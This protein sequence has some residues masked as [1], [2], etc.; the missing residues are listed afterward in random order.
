MVKKRLI[1][2]NIIRGGA[3]I[4]LGDNIYLLK[5]KK[6]SQGGIDIGKD[7][8][9]EGDEVVKMNPK[10]IKVVT[11]QKI[12]G[13]KSPAELVV[14]ASSTGEQE[15]VFNNV[16]RYQEKFKDRNNLNDDGTK[17]AKFG[18]KK[19]LTGTEENNIND[20]YSKHFLFKKDDVSEKIQPKVPLEALGFESMIGLGHIQYDNSYFEDITERIKDGDLGLYPSKYQNLVSSSPTF[21]FIP[22]SIGYYDTPNYKFFK[23]KNNNKYYALDAFYNTTGNINENFEELS[24]D[25]IRKLLPKRDYIGGGELETALKAIEKL[26]GIKDYI[27]TKSE[28]YGVNPNNVLHRILQEGFASKLAGQYNKSSV[29]DQLNFPWQ[30]YIDNEVSGYFDIGLDTYMD[31]VKKGNVKPRRELKFVETY[32]PNEDGRSVKYN[33][34]DFINLYDAIE[35]KIAFM[36][37]LTKLGKERG[38]EG[39]DLKKF[40][41]GAYNMG[42]FRNQKLNDPEYMKKYDFKDYYKLGGMKQ[43]KDRKKA[44]VGG[45][46]ASLIGEYGMPVAAG[47]TQGVNAGLMLPINLGSVI[48]ANIYN[49]KYLDKTKKAT[50]DYNQDIYDTSIQYNVDKHNKLTELLDK[51]HTEDLADLEKHKITRKDAIYNPVKLNTKVNI[52]PRLQ[53]V[54]RDKNKNIE[55]IIK[56]T[57][58]SKDMLNRVRQEVLRAGD[59]AIELEGIK[60][61]AEKQLQNQDILQRQKTY[62]KQIDANLRLDELRAKDLQT[63]YNNLAALKRGYNQNKLSTELD[64]LKDTYNTESLKRTSDYNAENEYREGRR[65]NRMNLIQG[66]SDSMGQFFNE[67]NNSAMTMAKLQAM[68]SAYG[69]NKINTTSEFKPVGLPNPT[70]QY[71]GNSAYN[72][73]NNFAET[74]AGQKLIQQILANGYNFKLGGKT[75]IKRRNK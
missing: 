25:N 28:E 62:E 2:P 60:E 24:Y 47:A 12:M 51:Y 44:A 49:K 5:G 21:T 48:G 23:D 53:I 32:Q 61:T 59:K 41:N 1:A 19:D 9:A 39:N 40:V 67:I 31:N 68:Q 36:E 27:K 33:S 13:G 56:N 34:A 69:N 3:A 38:F 73:A 35:A 20:E 64:Y 26:P 75:K 57:S 11:A 37:Y 29:K 58:S 55:S 43:F 65:E 16:F 42:E 10:S 30:D 15:E 72:S 45:A 71:F 46:W 22:G 50:L 6:H 4:P 8:E 7:L 14:N 54:E 17:K 70:S 74:Q 52:N 63:Y 18:K 66:I